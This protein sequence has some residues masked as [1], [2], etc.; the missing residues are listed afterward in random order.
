MQGDV[1]AFSVSFEGFGSIT[2]WSG[3]LVEDENGSYI[4][5]L[6]HLTRNIEESDEVEEI[7]RSITS[8]YAEFRRVQNNSPQGVPEESD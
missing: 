8:G 5:T 1:I 4:R 3:Q 7:W 6:W 2:S